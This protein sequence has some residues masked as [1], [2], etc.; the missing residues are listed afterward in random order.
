MVA[1]PQSR[2]QLD[3]AALLS[4]KLIAF[5]LMVG[6]HLDTM[7][8]GGALGIHASLGRVVFPLFALVLGLNLAR[9]DDWLS[10]LTRTAPRL[11]AI[12]VVATPIYAHLMGWVHFNVLFTLAAGVVAVA[13][14][15]RGWWLAAAST[16]IAAGW[17]VDYGSLGVLAVLG[18]WMASRL[19]LPLL[20]AAAWV[21]VA[22]VPVNGSLWSLLVLPLVAAAA[23]VQGDAPR[24][25]WLFWAGYPAHLVAIALLGFFL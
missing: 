3:N 12:G 6:D 17:T 22:V 24:F 9:S 5:G 14:V 10:L 25:A 11:A 16:V 2:V 19:G 20:V 13:F 7:V 23:Q 15:Q 4:L 21:S 1:I 8:F 18:A